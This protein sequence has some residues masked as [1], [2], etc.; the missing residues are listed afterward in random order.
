MQA[1]IKNHCP[2]I[3]KRGRQKAVLSRDNGKPVEL[4][5]SQLFKLGSTAGDSRRQTVGLALWRD[6]RPS[7]RVGDVPGW[8]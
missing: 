6:L 7:L 3:G 5:Q 8:V 2:K 4:N 1:F